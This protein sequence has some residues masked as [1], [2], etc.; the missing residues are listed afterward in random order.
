MGEVALLALAVGIRLRSTMWEWAGAVRAELPQDG[1]SSGWIGAWLA[2][3]PAGLLNTVLEALGAVGMF[4]VVRL[5]SVRG[6]GAAVRESAWRRTMDVLCG[7]I[8]SLKKKPPLYMRG[9]GSGQG[10]TVKQPLPFQGWRRGLAAALLIWLNPA[11]LLCGHGSGATEAWIIPFIVF[12]IFACSVEWWLAGGILVGVAAM[13]KGQV[14]LTAPVFVLWPLFMNAPRAATRCAIGMAAGVALSVAPTLM[15]SGGVWVAGAM[16]VPAMVRRK[17]F[18]RGPLGSIAVMAPLAF[19]LVVWPA[20]LSPNRTAPAMIFLGTLGLV[21][22]FAGRKLGNVWLATLIALAGSCALAL[23]P[24]LF[25]GSFEG[26]RPIVSEAGLASGE[27]SAGASRV[28][29][30]LRDSFGVSAGDAL[31]TIDLPALCIHHVVTV[32]QCLAGVYVITVLIAGASA[33]VHGNR[34]DPRVLVGLVLPW[35]LFHL[36]L[37]GADDRAVVWGAALGACWVA[38][39]SGTPLM[40]LLLS[41]LAFVLVASGMNDEGEFLLKGLLRAH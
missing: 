18:G 35:V 30:I 28:A 23:C 16:L 4:L 26:L 25:G 11:L 27:I 5:W 24:M 10:E 9:P 40:H 39:G 34:N 12:A 41:G 19:A 13:L 1:I 37:T 38:V 2:R 8:T 6:D 21:L 33:G 32:Q 17:W 14:M 15:G 22:I 20:M 7:W 29:R 3:W 36:L 31:W